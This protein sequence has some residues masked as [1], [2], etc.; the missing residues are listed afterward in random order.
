M[1]DVLIVGGGIVGLA[2]AHRARQRGLDALVLDAGETPAAHVA[3][4]MLAPVTEAEFG[5]DVSL[6]LESAERYPAWAAELGV[7]LREAGTLVVARD[8]DDAGTLDR[9]HA[10]RTQLGLA[11]ERLLPSA[12]RRLEP[13][14]A[15]TVRLA[16]HVPTDRSVDPRALLDALRARV[17]VKRARVTAISDGAVT[18]D[19]GV[20]RAPEIVLAAGAWSGAL[21]APVRP[22]KGQILRL[23]GDAGLVDRTVRTVDGYLVPRGD[24]RYV[25][26]ATVEDRGWDP[27]PTAGGVYEILR[28]M[29]EVVP[30][31][32]ELDVEELS[33]GFRPATPDNEP[34]IERREDGVIVATGHWRNGILLAP[35]TA[36]HVVDLMSRVA[37]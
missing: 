18:T 3:A 5:D 16:L 23:R 26:G 36:D 22:V 32:L 6:A 27:H 30:G 20:L 19:D 11:A 14:L 7:E 8:A 2:V 34:L 17:T 35:A 24:G 21:G 25:L 13:A 10:F 15:P 9:L 4:G 37:A 1:T 28:D 12:A 33:V 29:S 31:V